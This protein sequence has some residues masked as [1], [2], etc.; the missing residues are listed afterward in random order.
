MGGEI[1]LITGAARSGKSE[2]AEKLAGKQVIPVLYIATAWRHESDQEWGERITKHQLRRPRDWQTLE[3]P[4]NLSET[5]RVI[6]PPACL[7]IDS[8]GTWTAN[9]LDRDEDEWLNITGEF[10]SCLQDSS[11]TLLLVAEETGW[12]VIP[13]YESGRLFRDRLGGLIRRV[14]SIAH[15]VYLVTGGHA[16]NLSLL[17]EKLD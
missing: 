1:I 9:L 7:L 10:I 13:A 2:W 17:G 12:G 5:I 14:G 6:V 16:L 8:L 15:K 3:I 4:I 11:L